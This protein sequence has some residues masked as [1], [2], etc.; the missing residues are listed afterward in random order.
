[1]QPLAQENQIHLVLF[2]R[3]GPWT[4]VHGQIEPFQTENFFLLGGGGINYKRTKFS[5]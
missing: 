2:N 4:S 5:H 1:M 3:I